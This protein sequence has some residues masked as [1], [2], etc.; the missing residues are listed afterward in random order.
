MDFQGTY[1]VIYM[2]WKD[3][4]RDTFFLTKI[5]LSKR[6]GEV[7]EKHKYLLQSQSKKITSEEK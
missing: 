5:A 2:S 3:V 1:P 7:F 6:I 4:D